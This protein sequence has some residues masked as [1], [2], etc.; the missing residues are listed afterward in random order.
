MYFSLSLYIFMDILY[1]RII[2]V[3]IDTSALDQSELSVRF[4]YNEIV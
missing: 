3:W 2:F 1:N 4:A